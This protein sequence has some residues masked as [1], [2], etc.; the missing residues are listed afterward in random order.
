MSEE[1]EQKKWKWK[2][3]ILAVFVWVMPVILIFAMVIFW[4]TQEM[5]GAKT[6]SPV[7]PGVSGQTTPPTTAD[8]AV[9][10]GPQWSKKTQIFNWEINFE[11]RLLI[12]VLLAGAL[13]S[14]IH[15]A[16]SFSLYKGIGTLDLK[17][18]SWY[19]MRVPVGAGLAVVI[20]LLIQGG[21]FSPQDFD[22]TN[23]FSTLGLAALVGLFSTQ[24]LAKLREIFNTMFASSSKEREEIEAKER[25]G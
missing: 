20:T 18:M 23:P 1:Q 11:L 3:R 7:E 9:T 2:N 22:K 13:G 16:S 25:K 19:F 14:S 4:P 21:I 15:A 5:R 6:G 17:W 24:A 10:P 8:P 12:L